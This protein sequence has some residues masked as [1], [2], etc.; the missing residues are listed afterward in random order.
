M[1]ITKEDEIRSGKAVVK[2]TRVTV[3]D[4]VETFHELGRSVSEVS[5]DFD[6]SEEEV[7]EA[8]RYSHSRRSTEVKA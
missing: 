3:E 4:V 8:L 2:D 5:D 6:I 1:T 7:E